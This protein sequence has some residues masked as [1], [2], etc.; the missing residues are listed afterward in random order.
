[1]A[2]LLKT[3]SHTQQSFIY[4]T[5][6]PEVLSEVISECLNYG[7]HLSC[8]WVEALLQNVVHTETLNLIEG[9]HYNFTVD[10]HKAYTII[11]Y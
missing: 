9:C 10:Q 8:E 11:T 2:Y 1:M 3:N 7:S 6:N 4:V 5:E